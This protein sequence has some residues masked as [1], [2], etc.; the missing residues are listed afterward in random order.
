MEGMKHSINNI[1]INMH[2]I[3]GGMAG[4]EYNVRQFSKPMSIMN[5]AFP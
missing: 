2:H 1:S 4:M 3:T 5:P